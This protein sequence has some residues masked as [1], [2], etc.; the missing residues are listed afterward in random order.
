M[1]FSKIA[2][3]FCLVLTIACT[4]C[5]SE[6]TAA[7]NESAAD[8]GVNSLSPVEENENIQESIDTAKS[9]TLAD[10]EAYLIYAKDT[11]AVAA[12]HGPD[13]DIS[14]NFCNAEGDQ[15]GGFVGYGH[16]SDGWTLIISR[17]F[18]EDYDYSG[19]GVGITDYDGEKNADRTY[20]HQN[21]LN[22]EQMSTEKMREIGLD[23]LDGHCCLVGD[24]ATI[25]SGNS[26]GITFG[27]TW[28]DDYYF[29]SFQDIDGFADRFSYFAGDGTPL[30]EYFEGY[31]TLDIT[32]MINMFDVMLVQDGGESDESKNESMCD[33]LKA[34]E[35]YLIYTG[36]DG[37]QQRFDLLTEE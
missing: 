32:T 20:P 37:T 11:Y 16:P 19:I 18:P 6:K 7:S 1:K 21:Y 14:G 17:E 3:A 35:P 23:F 24:G 10:G 12:F 5:S 25:Y 2:S 8:T 29:S 13:G 9:L 30:E 33:E 36:P 27:I 34:C 22:I 4:G 31:S 15:V 26:F 28:F